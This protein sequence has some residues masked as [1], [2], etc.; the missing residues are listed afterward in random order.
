MH[1]LSWKEE[2]DEIE[3]KRGAV[4]L[5]PRWACCRIF[6]ALRQSELP[7]FPKCQNPKHACLNARFLSRPLPPHTFYSCF[8]PTVDAN[9]K[10]GNSLLPHHVLPPGTTRICSFSVLLCFIVFCQIPENGPWVPKRTA[11]RQCKTSVTHR[12]FFQGVKKDTLK[13]FWI[14]RKIIKIHLKAHFRGLGQ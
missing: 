12:W 11:T 13:Q 8:I 7:P 14:K 6:W 9:S 5:S 1:F 3:M 4:V 2:T 10:P